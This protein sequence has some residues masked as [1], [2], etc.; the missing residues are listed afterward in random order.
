MNKNILAFRSPHCQSVYSFVLKF[1]ALFVKI[2]RGLNLKDFLCVIF[3]I[4]IMSVIC[5]FSL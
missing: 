4:R 1:A 3:A 5:A 2:A